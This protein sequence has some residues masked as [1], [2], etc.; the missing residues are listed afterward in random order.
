MTAKKSEE[1]WIISQLEI[2]RW[3][4]LTRNERIRRKEENMLLGSIVVQK[5]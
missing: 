1:V 4:E 3:E 2:Q 5:V